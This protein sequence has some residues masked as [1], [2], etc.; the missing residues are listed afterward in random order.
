MIFVR[1]IAIL[2]TTAITKTFKTK[3]NT[4][5]KIIF[6]YLNYSLYCW[7]INKILTYSTQ[8]NLFTIFNL[9]FQKKSFKLPLS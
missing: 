4:I 6:M 2:K 1:I 5:I 3:I 8:I 9:I 7:N